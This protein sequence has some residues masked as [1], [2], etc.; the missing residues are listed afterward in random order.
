MTRNE[1]LYERKMTEHL[2]TVDKEHIREYFSKYA[3]RQQVARFLSFYEIFKLTQGVK[4][5]VLDCG[6]YHGFSAFS[7][8][9]F[10]AIHQPYSYH[11]RLVIFDTWEGLTEPSEQEKKLAKHNPEMQR[12]AFGDVSL[13]EQK[14]CAELFK[15]NHPLGHVWDID[16]V[17]GDI[18]VTAEKYIDKH[19]ELLIRILYLDMDL[20]EPTKA[21]LINFIPRMSK[22]SIVAFD[23]AGNSR[24]GG[25]TRALL[26]GFDLPQ[27]SLRCFE[28]EPNMSYMI[29]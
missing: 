29:L 12:G 27:N 23:E 21:A 18:C 8:A 24:W 17:Q 3:R 20:F 4:G 5:C 2:R 7:W 19:P 13:K 11:D 25:E 9:Q 1:K 14:R 6:T 26:E 28:Y 16:F 10:L 15:W 22:G